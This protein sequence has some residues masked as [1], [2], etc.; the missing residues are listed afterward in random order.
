[1]SVKEVEKIRLT[2][3]I[4]VLHVDPVVFISDH[5]SLRGVLVEDLR[6]EKGTVG[7][8]EKNF[9]KGASVFSLNLL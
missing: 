6:G 1:V 7:H 4:K 5:Q 2:S 8:S 3:G 9:C